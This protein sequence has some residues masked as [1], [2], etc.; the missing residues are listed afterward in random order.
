MIKLIQFPWSTYCM[1]TRWLLRFG[2]VPHE[3]INIPPLDRSLPW[4]LTQQRSYRVPLL[5]DV[6]PENRLEALVLRGKEIEPKACV[7]MLRDVLRL[8]IRLAK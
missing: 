6:A 4:S 2:E 8:M 7:E 3:V 5:D 1:V